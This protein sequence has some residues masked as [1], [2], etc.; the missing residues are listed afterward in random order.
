MG[1]KTGPLPRLTRLSP[2]NPYGAHEELLK[3]Q[4]LYPLS[5]DSL[6]RSG[7]VL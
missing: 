5:R 6:N 4:G 2:T 3:K 1:G 7:C